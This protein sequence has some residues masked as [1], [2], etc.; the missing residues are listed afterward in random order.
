MKTLLTFFLLIC[1]SLLSAQDYRSDFQKMLKEGPKEKIPPLLAKWQNSKPE[2]PEMFIAHFNYYFNESRKE[3]IGMGTQPGKGQNLTLRDTATNET[4]G[5]MYTHVTYED[6]LF[7]IA[8]RYIEEG[9]SKN[10]NRLDMH[11][12]RLYALREAGYLEEHVEG[13]LS[14]IDLHQQNQSRWR[15]TDDKII[16]EGE[17]MFK[18]SIQDYNHALFNLE[19]TP[20]RE[21]IEKISRKMMELYPKDIENYSNIGVCRLIDQ[22]Y[23]EAL[24]FFKKASDINPNDAIVLSNIAYTYVQMEKPKEALKY[25]DKIAKVG[26]PEMAEFAKQESAKLRKK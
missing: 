23:A 14:V 3:M 19:E 4:A 5:F 26:D 8:Q 7:V 25:Y 16:T 6:S 2:D 13:I 1:A 24:S 12:G 9:I 17:K 10:P 20:Y 18:G 22:N 11:F 21:G 15:W